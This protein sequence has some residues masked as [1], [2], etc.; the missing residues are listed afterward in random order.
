MAGRARALPDAEIEER[1]GNWYKIKEVLRIAYT[2]PF[3]LSSMVGVVFASLH[4]G[5]S[6]LAVLI[7]L[8]VFFLALFVNFSNDY[9]DFK[10]GVDL[11]RFEEQDPKV[12]EKVTELFDQRVFW[13]GN[14]FDKGIITERQGKALMVAIAAVCVIVAIPIVLSAGFLAVALGL[15]GMGLA[16][17]YTAPPLNLG[18]RGLGEIDVMLSFTLMA[19]FSY[20]VIGQNFSLEMLFLALSIGI[21][22]MMVRLCDEAPGY[23]AHVASGEKNLCVR[24]GLENMPRLLGALM[25]IFYVT[26]A[27]ASILN[28]F[29]LIL[30]LTVPLALRAMGYLRKREDEIRFWRT[31][32]ETFKL[33]VFN[34]VLIILVLIVQNVLTSA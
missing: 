26:I 21:S 9:F 31:I 25:L 32:P 14:S 28:P 23:D 4:Y 24:V 2:L 15:I 30:F 22:M 7:P 34:Q 17:F 1:R 16:F 33:A 19:F 5:F 13:S 8:D 3:V 20:F 10:S 11:K 29:F 6:F 12:M 18:A 27:V